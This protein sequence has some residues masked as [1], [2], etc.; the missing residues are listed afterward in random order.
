MAHAQRLSQS[1]HAAPALP[2]VA[3]DLASWRGE[4]THWLHVLEKRSAAG[5]WFGHSWAEGCAGL[6]VGTVPH[7]S[8]GDQVGP[9]G[10][11]A[12]GRALGQFLSVIEPAPVPGD[13]RAVLQSIRAHLDDR[14]AGMDAWP[15][16]TWTVG[17]HS[18]HAAVLQFAGAWL[19]I[20]S[21]VD[22]SCVIAIGVGTSPDN[23]EI[24][25]ENGHRYSLDFSRPT[26]EAEYRIGSQGRMPTPNQF[27]A[28]L[29][30]FIQPGA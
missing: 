9:L 3:Y 18:L 29:A 26:F 14:V 8:F 1:D 5:I 27:H 2:F 12:P 21:E 13:R 17:E 4:G 28:D 7:T 22:E 10:W 16:T 19:A 11:E 24:V 30:R 23:L 6:L 20:T 25:P 15:C